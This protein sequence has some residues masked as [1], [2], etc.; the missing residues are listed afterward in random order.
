L[1][2][3]AA[4]KD[5]RPLSWIPIFILAV[6]S[7]SLNLPSAYADVPITLFKSFAGNINVTATGATLRTQPNTGNTCAVTN[8]PV[9]IPL[10]G[11][12]AGS[13]ITAAYLYWAGSGATVDANVTFNGTAITADRT[14][15]ASTVVGGTTY[16]FFSGFKD[17]T[18][19]VT[20]NGN[21]TFADLTVDTS[22]TYC[23][24][25]AVLSG[26][27]LIVIYAN[28]S[29]D[30]R[31]INAWDG[32][33]VFYNSSISLTPTNFTIPASPI[34]GKHLVVTWE[35]DPDI[36]GGENILFNG[37]NL[38]DSLN[39]AGSLWNSTINTIPTS[40]SYGVDVDVF[41]V[42]GYLHAGDTSATAVYS[43]GGDLVILS[44]QVMSVT[45][46][47]VADLA[48]TK[49]H[50]DNFYVGAN[51]IYTLT[52][53]N[54]GPNS[55]TGTITVT[56]T[57]ATGLTYVSAAGTGWT[58]SVASQVVTCT[59]PGPLANG[60]SAPIIGLTVAVGA[61]ASPSVTNNA[62]VTSSTFDNV[63]S[64]NSATDVATVI[65][66]GIGNKPLYLY[67]GASY[68][69]SRTIP[70]GT[71]ATVT[72][73]TT[74]SQTWTQRPVA[75]GNITID[76]AISATVPVY[77]Q[78]ARSGSAGNISIT[79]NLQ[80]SSGGT[81]LTQTANCAAGLEP[82]TQQCIYNLPL[83]TAVTC[84]AGNS[85]RLTIQNNST[86]RTLYIHPVSGAN[87]SRVVLPSTTVI[88]VTGVAAYS[89]PSPSTSTA[90]SYAPG[91]TVYL[92]ATASDPFGSYDVTSAS[93]TIRNST[94]AA[95]ISGASMAQVVD[96]GTLTKIYEYAYTIPS[97]GPS[98]TWTATAIAREGS[99]GT[100]SD[101]G[102]TAFGVALLPSITVV[103][104]ALIESDPINGST[105][106]KAIP[107][108]VLIYS[109]TVM[110][111]GLGTADSSSIYI[112]DPIPANTTMSVDTG[113]GNPVTF[114]CSTSPACGLTWNYATAVK[115]SSQAGGGAPYNYTP[116]TS[117][118][119]PLVKGIWIEP[120]GVLN[121][122]GAY[123][124]VQFRVR[125]N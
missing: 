23:N 101:S 48:L 18:A 39:T 52:V 103:K 46:A 94:G 93:I 55:A 72:I 30:F 89:A 63:A 92:R 10:S 32:F 70:S 85:W 122:S 3:R 22:A 59:R 74:A 17:V 123:F 2:H 104:S 125:I 12:P 1:I 49:T 97:S 111:S 53:T 5:F 42:S 68:T 69:L 44:T 66:P 51:G 64:N 108:A 25:S 60:A 24:V 99:E 14:F 9:S 100:V 82:A 29:E 21:Y 106:P 57:L 54:N 58:C 38:S 91:S 27:A 37:T 73:G 56:D 41:D 16:N 31:V 50:V 95:V 19:Y 36:S 114:T 79:V 76:P 7:F 96:S 20:G 116:G 40:A 120:A 117:G 62:T 80:C 107:G 90:S 119:D 84:A 61:A 102:S 65:T 33:Q 13:T 11:I 87:Y 28:A 71:P 15:T 98:G 6:L 35:G 47:P 88:D 124:T 8:G 86:T 45:N 67:S 75:Q 118:F 115:Y 34:N 4:K 105:N 26:A 83:A 78:A 109:I 43:T 77:L 121:A 81:I 112:T 110:N 113:S